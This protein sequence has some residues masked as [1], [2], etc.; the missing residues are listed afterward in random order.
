M[1]VPRSL[2]SFCAFW[3]WIHDLAV[4]RHGPTFGSMPYI[5][6]SDD[7]VNEVM[8]SVRATCRRLKATELFGP[9][10]AALLAPGGA[11]G[12]VK[13][14]LNGPTPA[15]PTE[16]RLAWV[17][18]N[19]ERYVFQRSEV[20]PAWTGPFPRK[21]VNTAP[22]ILNYLQA[23]MAKWSAATTE[24]SDGPRNKLDASASDQWRTLD[25]VWQSLAW[26]QQREL[27]SSVPAAPM[28]SRTKFNAGRYAAVLEQWVIVAARSSESSSESL[29]SG[30]ETGPLECVVVLRGEKGSPL[31][32]DH[33][34]P[35]VSKPRYDVLKTLI[36][37]GP[38]GLSLA[39]L[40]D[41]KNKGR[42]TSAERILK[43]LS[44][45]STDWAQAI[46]LPGTAG[47]K[48][49]LLFRKVRA[50]R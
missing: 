45:L 29:E 41:K 4:T 11:T 25:N 38:D 5:S 36:E 23:E 35:P 17:F 42:R 47:R 1:E 49:R 31:V 3:T 48:Y 10:D 37:A 15:T 27:I 24:G 39:D 34:V 40:T 6:L 8:K 26:L 12:V 20:C 33:E 43:N 14:G 16:V 30:G 19:C 2:A 13:S 21:P 32:L 28:G 50:K 22:A 7:E 44:K 9:D 18:R 46:L